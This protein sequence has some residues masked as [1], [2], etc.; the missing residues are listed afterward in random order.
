MKKILL[1]LA[2]ALPFA[3][4]SCGGQDPPNMYKLSYG[5]NGLVT[6]ACCYGPGS[7][8]SKVSWSV[9]MPIFANYA[10]NN[11]VS[12]FFLTEN[13]QQYLPELANQVELVKQIIDQNPKAVF[14]NGHSFVLLK[15]RDMPVSE[16]NILHAFFDFRAEEPCA[17]FPGGNI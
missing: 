12:G 13:W 7:D 8:C 9:V 5:H 17:N 4:S 2:V 14:L 3:L 16:D 15:N 6:Y 1:T 10:E 11:N